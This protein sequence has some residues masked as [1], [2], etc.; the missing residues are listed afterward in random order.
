MSSEHVEYMS[1]NDTF[2]L[3]FTLE[4]EGVV[5]GHYTDKNQ[6]GSYFVF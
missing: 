1:Q 2:D 4:A 6:Q 3:V 5:Q